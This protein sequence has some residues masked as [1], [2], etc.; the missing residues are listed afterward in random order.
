MTVSDKTVQAKER[1]SFF[2]S[3]EEISAK[4]SKKLATN[5]L[6]NPSRTLDITEIIATANASKN[7]KKVISTLPDVI[8]VSHTENCFNYGTLYK[9]CL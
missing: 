8:N 9:L 4:V 5:V 6:E 7:P 3:L 2:K 1:D